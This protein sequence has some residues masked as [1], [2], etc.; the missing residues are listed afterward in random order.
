M[1]KL[2]HWTYIKWGCLG[3]SAGSLVLS[4]AW[5]WLAG[6]PVQPASQQPEKDA[7]T[8]VEKPSIVER[9]GERMVWRLNAEKAD[10]ELRGMRL[11]E[12]RLE[13]FSES[14]QVI[15]VQGNY[16]WFN[17]VTRNIRFEGAVVVGYKSWR[18]KSE[19]LDYDSAKQ[20]LHI[21]GAFH[22]QGDD[23]QARGKNMRAQRN[24]QRLWVENGIWIED[25]RPA[26][27]DKPS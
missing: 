27:L 2:K 4:F 23:I 21:P 18:L 26:T 14:G 6:P 13:L 11:T 17:P 24:T 1:A 9:D 19:V 3:I 7:G 5:L 10:Q 22:L 25:S 16:A 8:R 20:E 15:P 12:P